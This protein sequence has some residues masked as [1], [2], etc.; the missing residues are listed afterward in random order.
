[1]GTTG[2]AD[3]WLGMK[4]HGRG[5]GTLMRQ[6]LCAFMF[7]H[8]RATEVTSAAF[9]DNPA[10][11]AVSRKF[12]YRANG[13]VRLKRRDGEVSLSQNLVLLPATLNR[14][15]PPLEVSGVSALRGFLGLTV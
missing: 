13:V 7:D 14:P 12:S 10:S 9:L 15:E 6:A 8:L 5:I 11:L 3:S 1:M 2:E 4:H